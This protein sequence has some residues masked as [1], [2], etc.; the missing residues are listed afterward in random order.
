LDTQTS[1][2]IAAI[3]ISI[4]TF[5]FTILIDLKYNTPTKKTKNF[6][7]KYKI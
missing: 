4:F 3:S 2:S 5:I 6:L 1:L 7:K